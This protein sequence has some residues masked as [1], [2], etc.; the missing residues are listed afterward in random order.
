MSPLTS[1]MRVQV[2]DIPSLITQSKSAGH[3]PGIMPC[4]W[5]LEQWSHTDVKAD[6][7][8]HSQEVTSSS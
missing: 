1:D 7:K 2:S 3:T 4:K 6:F 5:A 8:S